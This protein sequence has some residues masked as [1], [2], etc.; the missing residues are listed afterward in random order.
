MGYNA[1]EIVNKTLDYI[2]QSNAQSFREFY[3]GIAKNA[4]ERLFTQ[5]QVSE[6]DGC[7]IWH[8][9]NSEDEARTAEKFLLGKGMKGGSG[10]G[11]KDTKYV[12][13]YRITT[14]TVE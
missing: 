6:E 10:G 3:V 11:D 2:S 7:W 4:K 9:A 13:C 5:H 12:Y 14:K 1:S 8:L